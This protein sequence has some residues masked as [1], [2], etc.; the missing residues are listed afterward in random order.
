[1]PQIESLIPHLEFFEIIYLEKGFTIKSIRRK[2]RKLKDLKHKNSDFPDLVVFSMYGSLHGFLVKLVLGGKF[3]I[4]N[5]FGG[6]DILGSRNTSV[7]WMFRNWLTKYLSF[8]TARRVN[9]IIVKSSNLS[10]VLRRKVST[11]V[12]II[13]NGV[14]LQF[15]EVIKNKDELR[16]NLEWSTE[17][18][19]ILFNLRR[20][21][22]KHEVV[23]NYPLAK[24][25]VSMLSAITD[26]RFR[27]E[28]ITNK[29]HKEMVILLNA[30]DCLLV[31]SLHEGSPNIVKEAMACNL[32]IV[33][34]ECGDIKERLG[35]V[36]N[37]YVS[38]KYD[39]KELAQLCL[40]LIEAQQRS[41]G[42]NEIISQGLE[43]HSIANTILRVLASV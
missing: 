9:H 26:A 6:S 20:G 1:M 42:R 10:G 39:P 17:E 8:Y 22:S 4:V 27:L 2:I 23:K 34:V 18:F 14:D 37:S 28:I 41:N 15:F 32:P 30:A 38:S 13:P 40:K 43:T 33:S 35:Q 16:K 36:R 12:T 29:T 25:V 5:T 3:K 11:P 21:N 31:T 24:E 7:F 19:V